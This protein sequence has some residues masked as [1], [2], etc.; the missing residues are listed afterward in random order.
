MNNDMFGNLDKEYWQ[1]YADLK[2]SC[3]EVAARCTTD[4][5]TEYMIKAFSQPYAIT[6]ISGKMAKKNDKS[7]WANAY[8]L[9]FFEEGTSDDKMTTTLADSD[10]MRSKIKQDAPY[11]A[12]AYYGKKP[13]S[14]ET[15]RQA[16]LVHRL[17]ITS[18]KLS[19]LIAFSPE[20]AQTIIKKA[21]R[22][23]MITSQGSIQI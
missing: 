9:T 18:I 21:D 19:A 4:T 3:D 22:N 15:V 5:M 12:C 20:E 8:Y 13:A 16:K 6:S 23:L 1:I 14:K 7:Y 17:F 10:F 2:K 11:I